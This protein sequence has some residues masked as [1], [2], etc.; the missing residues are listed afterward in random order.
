MVFLNTLV[1]SPYKNTGT[2]GATTDMDG[3]PFVLNP[4]ISFNRADAF[5]VSFIFHKIENFKLIKSNTKNSLFS[6]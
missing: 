3:V 4:A 6:L 2:L 1:S 5:D